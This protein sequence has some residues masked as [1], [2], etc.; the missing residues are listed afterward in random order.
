MNPW[1]LS[2]SCLEL[3]TRGLYILDEP[4]ICTK[5][6]LQHESHLYR[7][8]CSPAAPESPP[9][10]FSVLSEDPPQATAAL[11]DK[12]LWIPSGFQSMIHITCALWESWK[13]NRKLEGRFMMHEGDRVLLVKAQD[14]GLTLKR[15]GISWGE[16]RAWSSLLSYLQLGV[17]SLCGAY[18]HQSHDLM[19]QNRL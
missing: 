17:G 4:T 19:G 3:H 1:S 9:P 16:I 14:S 13:L 7:I 6:L 8:K 18:H 2:G 11:C 5:P 12:L 15:R 10:L